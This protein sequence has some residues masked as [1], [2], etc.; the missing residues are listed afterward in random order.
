MAAFD[1]DEGDDYKYYNE[2]DDNLQQTFVEN[3]HAYN[4]TAIELANFNLAEI[5]TSN[6]YSIKHQRQIE[7]EEKFFL[8]QLI[9]AYKY[10]KY[11]EK[12]N[13]QEWDFYKL[14]KILKQIPFYVKKSPLGLLL[15][16]YIFDSKNFIIQDR[17]NKLM[18]VS[19]KT[20]VKG[21]AVVPLNYIY[22]VY[23]SDLLRYVKLLHEYM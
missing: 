12:Y 13:L 16:Y 3:Q 18:E 22:K 8:R 6:P 1:N 4:E 7:G 9:Y 19:D 23:A 11:T 14:L 5:D 20:Q 21:N 2:E 15:S 17:F 10:I